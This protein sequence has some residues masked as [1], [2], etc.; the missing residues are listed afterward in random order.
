MLQTSRR[1]NPSN[2]LTEAMMKKIEALPRDWLEQHF[3]A[4]T[5]E[6]MK[7]LLDTCEKAYQMHAPEQ[8]AQAQISESDDSQYL[9]T[10]LQ[11]VRKDTLD[12]CPKSTYSILIFYKTNTM[13]ILGSSL[14]F[15]NSANQKGHYLGKGC[16]GVVKAAI[17]IWPEARLSA[18][19]VM[20]IA[21][22]IVDGHSIPDYTANYHNEFLIS[23]DMGVASHIGVLKTTSLKAKKGPY[24]L[25]MPMEYLGTSLKTQMLTAKWSFE[26][27]LHLIV[28]LLGKIHHM[29]SIGIAHGDI[30]PDNLLLLN[31]VI[32]I[33]DFGLSK[34]FAIPTFCK[35]SRNY[36][37]FRISEGSNLD[38][39]SKGV[40]FHN[41]PRTYSKGCFLIA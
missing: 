6:G 8:T 16:F 14:P 7:A 4:F 5:A 36:I 1:R 30:K 38:L 11:K 39:Y 28:S 18:M 2:E 24:K 10:F 20:N 25:Y 22:R 26:E 40:I 17:Q 13:Y 41:L 3:L 27:R 34:R 15:Q 37:C 35:R 12:V 33:V 23:S 31:Q 19:K 29:H 32:N 9:D 21:E